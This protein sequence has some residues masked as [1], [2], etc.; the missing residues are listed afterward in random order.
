MNKEIWRPLPSHP[1]YFVSSHGRVAAIKPIKRIL[2]QFLD[3]SGYSIVSIVGIGGRV[4]VHNLVAAAFIGKKPFGVQV[5]HK[6]GIKGH[7]YP[8]NLEYI[9]QKENLRHAFRTGLM[10]NSGRK[11]K[12]T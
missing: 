6:D 4:R 11:K 5:N 1:R 7:N 2:T 8:D 3:K 10:K 12:E 9:S